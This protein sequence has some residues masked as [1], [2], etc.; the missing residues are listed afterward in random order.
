MNYSLWLHIE[1]HE[2]SHDGY[3][4]DQEEYTDTIKES[5]KYI[6]LELND[7]L[8]HELKRETINI[9]GEVIDT[10]ILYLNHPFIITN[11]KQIMNELVKCD[12][13]S[14]FCG[15]DNNIISIYD[16]RIFI[17]YNFCDEFVIKKKENEDQSLSTKI[18]NNIKINKG[19]L[20]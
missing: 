9:N 13:G 18:M 3:C 2:T 15:Y 19:E 5:Y 20:Y 4:T 16:A 6:F 10:Y 1:K 12:Y 11:Y 14:G 7:I 8:F 17:N